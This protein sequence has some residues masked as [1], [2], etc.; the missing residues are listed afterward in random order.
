MAKHIRQGVTL[1]CAAQAEGVPWST[2]KDWLNWSDAGKE[3]YAGFS[4]LIRG[5][6]A[7]AEMTMTRRMTRKSRS[8]QHDN[9]DSRN[10]QFWLERR[11]REDWWLSQK[12][13]A[14]KLSTKELA[15]MIVDEAA[16]HAAQDPEVR[17]TLLAKL[18][19]QEPDE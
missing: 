2:F 16:K 19:A 7:K 9:V 6:E 18:K 15:G 5:A 3:P 12:E 11:R 1:R 4:A 14:S 8:P 10:A 17:A 13:D